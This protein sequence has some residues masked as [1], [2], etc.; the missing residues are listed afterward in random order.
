M[1]ISASIALLTASL[2]FFNGCGKKEEAAKT[3]EAEPNYSSGNPVTA[4]VD[5]LGAV[6]QGKKR[7]EKTIDTVSLQQA[8]QV[9]QVE[10]DRYPKDLNELV[11]KGYLPRLPTPPYGMRF[12]YNASNGQVAV[13]R[14]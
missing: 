3:P 14:Q 13:V 12:T 5:Y 11:T 10:E 9:F 4:P 2:L 7:A 6:N 1:R 8:I